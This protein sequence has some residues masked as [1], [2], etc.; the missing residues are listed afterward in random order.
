MFADRLSQPLL[1]AACAALFVLSSGC[2]SMGVPS[3]GQAQ[4]AGQTIDYTMVGSGPVLVLQTGL[5]VSK[6]T[7]RAILPAL[8][9]EHTVVAFD[10]PGYGDSPA[11]ATRRDPCTIASEQHGLLKAIGAKPP[12]LLLGHSLGG[13][14]QYAF[15]LMYPSEVGGLVLLDP[16][17][18]RHWERMQV[19]APGAATFLQALVNHAFAEHERKEFDA[20][21]SC[22]AELGVYGTEASTG[23][24]AAAIPARLLLRTEYSPL[25]PRAFENMVHK[26]EPD[27]QRMINAPKLDYVPHSG[28]FIHQEQPQ[29]VL[30]A[31]RAVEA[32]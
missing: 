1:G 19:D 8:Q 13:T 7:W 10:R 5:G 17:H 12:Y 14:Y 26:L 18:P 25:E 15:A 22:L 16:T 11:A 21:T 9:K 32:H 27:W 24:I 3:T 23:K 31:L 28:H 4:V 6:S 20:Q 30:E 2:A 29:A